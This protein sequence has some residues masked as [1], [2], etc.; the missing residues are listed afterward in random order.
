MTP[1]ITAVTGFVIWSLFLLLLMELMRTRLVLTKAIPANGFK[2]D[3][4]NLSPFMQRLARAHANC[5][6]GLPIFGGLMLIAVVTGRSA[7][8]DPLAYVF[9]ATRI[10][11]SVIHLSSLSALAV[12]LRFSAFAVQMGIAVYWSVRLVVA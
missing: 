3:N 7:I 12:T 9:L 1:T 5:V 11:Q 6:E 8:T 4:S 2:P 10:L